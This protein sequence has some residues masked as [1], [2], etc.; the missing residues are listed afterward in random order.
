MFS[1][2]DFTLGSNYLQTGFS[3]EFHDKLVQSAAR[4]LYHVQHSTLKNF[5]FVRNYL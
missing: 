4:H 5:D 1:K 2:P 3:E